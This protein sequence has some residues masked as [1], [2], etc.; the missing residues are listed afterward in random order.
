M[1]LQHIL[2]LFSVIAATSS[3][4]AI[5]IDNY[6]SATNDRF[7]DADTPDQFFLSNFTLS[8]VGQDS[9]GRW[10]TLIGTNTIISANHYKPSGTIS[11]FP[12]NDPTSAAIQLGITTD[13]QR[14]GN[15]DLWVARLDDYAPS[16]IRIYDIATENIAPYT[17]MN[18][19][20]RATFS[21]RDSE[22][23][24]TGRSPSTFPNTQDQAYGTNLAF[25][26]FEGNVSGLGDVEAIQLNYDTN[27][28]ET[29]YESFFQGGDSGAPLLLDNG[30]NELLLIGINSF[31]TN[32]GSGNPVASYSSYV[33]N[34]SD[35]INSIV[36][37]YALI[38]EPGMIYL[39]GVAMI[40][41]TARRKR[42]V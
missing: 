40:G 22:V 25:D 10:A 35:E 32:D 33:G 23:F 8:G 30:N 2:A 29:A 41:L 27:P 16:T 9:N 36:A 42:T 17:G 12:D 15:S 37:Q 11:F 21:F 5:L 34:D 19:N 6:S 14:I 28:S 13:S 31:I 24:M 4:A 20:G 18:P 3:H 1:S 39:I 7:Q 38:P 26:F